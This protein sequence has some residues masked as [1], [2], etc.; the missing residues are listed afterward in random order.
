[1]RT[2]GYL[3]ALQESY[4]YTV[5]VWTCERFHICCVG[6]L[7]ACMRR[8]ERLSLRCEKFYMPWSNVQTIKRAKRKVYYFMMQ[9]I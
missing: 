3:V 1:L 6:Y 5:F 7:H 8:P 9:F 2:Y 4:D